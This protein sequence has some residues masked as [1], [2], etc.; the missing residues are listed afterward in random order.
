MRCCAGALK[1]GILKLISYKSEN[2][3]NW[4]NIYL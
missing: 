3:G 2:K 1:M 4:E